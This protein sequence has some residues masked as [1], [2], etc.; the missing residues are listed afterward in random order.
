MITWALKQKNK[1]KKKETKN[2]LNLWRR[3]SK[4]SLHENRRF[5][6]RLL[7]LSYATDWGDGMRMT[8][9]FSE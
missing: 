6:D 9:A 7:G 4:P 3:A 2:M 5:W 1:E 8:H